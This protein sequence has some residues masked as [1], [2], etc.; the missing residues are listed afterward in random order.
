MPKM[1]L[2][3][4]PRSSGDKLPEDSDSLWGPPGEET[5]AVVAKLL[6]KKPTSRR[7]AVII[8]HYH[9]LNETR[10]LLDSI[11]RWEE[12]PELILVADN[13][14]PHYDWSFTD[15]AT[16]PVT[17]LSFDDNPGYGLAI[18][19]AVK[20]LPT[21]I[22]QFLVVTHEVLLKPDCS[23][24]LL[25]SLHKTSNA[26]VAA[27]MLCYKDQPDRIFSLGGVLSKSGRAKHVQM[28]KSVRQAPVGGPGHLSVDWADGSCLMMARDV[29]EALN[30]F[31]PRY[32]LYVEEIDYQ[33][34][35]R[36][37]GAETVLNHDAHAFQTP[38]DYPLALKYRN[39]IAL[40][41]KMKPYLRRWRWEREIIRDI[42][43][44]LFRRTSQSP[45]E[46]L[47]VFPAGGEIFAPRANGGAQKKPHGGTT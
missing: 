40:S 17:V 45:L 47:K 15:D 19:R 4:P 9:R 7:Y 31:D 41:K 6:K 34:R 5:K 32:F 23:G 27:P 43:R 30:G 29:F 42:I 33:F 44:W 12:L 2:S 25:D 11:G 20:E 13:S 18:N 35:A 1:Q 26:A 39:H 28:A 16:I 21:D 8:V 14:A 37:A 38:S 10:E 46:L 22:S 36:L 3:P 24:L